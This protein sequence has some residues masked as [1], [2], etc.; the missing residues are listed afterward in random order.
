MPPTAL[1]PAGSDVSGNLVT[2]GSGNSTI[3]LGASTTTSQR[4]LRDVRVRSIWPAVL[5]KTRQHRG[6]RG[7]SRS[8]SITAGVVSLKTSTGGDLSVS[9]KADFLKSL[10]LTT[11]VGSGNVTVVPGAHH[12]LRPPLANLIQDGSTLN[13][14]GHT[15]TFKNAA[16]PGCGA[17]RDWFG[18]RATSS[19]DGNGNSTVYLQIGDRCRRAE[20]DRSG[21]RRPDRTISAGAATVTPAAGRTASSV[22]SNGALKL[23][24]GGS[25]SIDHRRPATPSR[26][27]GLTGATG[28]ATS[29]IGGSHRGCRRHQRQDLDLH[30]LQW[31]HSGQRHLRRRHGGTVKTLDQLNAALQANNLQATVDPPAS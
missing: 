26:L 31:R 1:R 27:F 5:R 17:G 30:L 15:I 19:T 23:S 28:S 25:R 12:Q 16:R 4:R 3:Y 22:S 24:T 20:G 8:S 9:G 21:N 14:N 29:F 11:A 6:Q 7:T 13:V 18:R 2:D 10:G